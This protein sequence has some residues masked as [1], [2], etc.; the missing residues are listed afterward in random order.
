MVSRVVDFTSYD[1][2]G[3]FL[4]EVSD[5]LDQ[6]KSFTYHETWGTLLTSVDIADNTTTYTY[7]SFGNLTYVDFPNA[8]YKSYSKTWS[9]NSWPSLAIYYTQC[10]APNA[11]D[12][13]NYYDAGGRLLHSRWD[14]M[15][16]SFVAVDK[17]YN[18]L[19]QV[20]RETKP[21]FF[22]NGGPS[23]YICTTYDIYGRVTKV[24]D[25]VYSDTAVIHYVYSG[26]TVSVTDPAGRGSSKTVNNMGQLI[27]STDDGGELTYSYNERGQLKRVYLN[28]EVTITNDYDTYGRL[29][30]EEDVNSGI[31]EYEYNNFGNIVTQTDANENE[32]SMT[33]DDACGILLNPAKGD[34][35]YAYVTSGPGIGQ[36]GTI[37]LSN[38]TSQS[39][40]YNNYGQVIQRHEHFDESDYDFS[41]SYDTYG[42]QVEI[43]YPNSFSVTNIFN[44]LGMLVEV[45]RTDNNDVIWKLDAVDPTGKPYELEQ[46]DNL[47]HTYY[48]YDYHGFLSRLRVEFRMML[49]NGIF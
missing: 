38:G 26:K 20:F 31:K 29:I 23:G 7:D 18:S 39:F 35:E 21:Y 4:L 16:N 10:V 28:E 17:E 19:G 46:G 43:V 33:Y 27:S 3:R 40:A 15:N 34:Y 1:N 49:T 41:Y 5:M 42:N 12:I 14:G 47:I 45:D 8:A 32:Y 37:S 25:S 30:S 13:K 6:T 36:I 24:K 48:N 2:K 9:L 11:P 44:N 22:N